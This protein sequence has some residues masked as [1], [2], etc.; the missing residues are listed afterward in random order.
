MVKQKL[1][2]CGWFKRNTVLYPF[3]NCLVLMGIM[4]VWGC[5]TDQHRIS[6]LRLLGS[7]QANDL[8]KIMNSFS[9][10][11]ILTKISHH[12]HVTTVQNLLYRPDSYSYR[13]SSRVMSKQ[14]RKLKVPLTKCEGINVVY[15]ENDSFI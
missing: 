6:K 9:S 11:D 3:F 4:A 8:R 2:C 1:W 10:L 15:V 13:K 7:F 14:L 12:C 5:V